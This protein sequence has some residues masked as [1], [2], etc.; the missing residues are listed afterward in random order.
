MTD[1]APTA[2]GGGLAV[3]EGVVEGLE[4]I[5]STDLVMPRI[6]IDHKE[7]KFTDNL[8][9]QSFDKLTVVLLG[10]V[11]GRIL[12]DESV[13]DGDKPL[14]KSFNFNEGNPDVDRFPWAT[15]KFDQA[16]QVADDDGKIV[17]PCVNC[18]LKEWGT[19]PQGK[20]PWCAEQHT[21]PLL[22]TLGDSGALGPALFTVQRTGI[23]PSKAYITNFQRAKTPLY[24]VFTE[25][26]LR[27]EKRGTVDYAVPSFARTVGTE[28]DQW[29]LY[30]QQYRSMRDFITRP[31]QRDDDGPAGTPSGAVPVTSTA[32]TASA[33]AVGED[34]EVPF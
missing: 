9:G 2:P 31:P 33:A 32:A 7:A 19:A 17:L 29:P 8:S 34:E 20:A 23:K 27:P 13:N 1:L 18:N 30:A 15:S 26:T 6:S 11:K 24:T 25:L 10:L 14:C 3:P 22:M 21:Y 16:A 5:E 28:Q 12:W 4:D